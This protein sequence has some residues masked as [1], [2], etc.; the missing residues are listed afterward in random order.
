MIF[1]HIKL[2]M[3]S[4]SGLL[5]VTSK[6]KPIYGLWLPVYCSTLY[7]RKLMQCKLHIYWRFLYNILKFT[8]SALVMV[9]VLSQSQKFKVRMAS[10]DITFISSFI[11]M[12]H[13]VQKVVQWHTE[14][15]L[16]SRSN[17]W[18]LQGAYQLQRKCCCIHKT[19]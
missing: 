15:V 12:C 13:L 8:S 3:V 6:S 2:Y 17:E 19:K 7:E 18:N 10:S 9:P 1:H 11:K 4:L 5:I 16:I 14:L